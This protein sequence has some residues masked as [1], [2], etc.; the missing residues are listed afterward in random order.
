M[1]E[2]LTVTDLKD[3]FG[4]SVSTQEGYRRDKVMP[5]IKVGGKIKYHKP[6]IDK[7]LIERAEGDEDTLKA[8]KEYVEEKK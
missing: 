4:I 5:F 2:W 7:W 6:T 3:D 1:N 8:W